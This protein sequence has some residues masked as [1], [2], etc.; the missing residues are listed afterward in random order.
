[1]NK[2][3]IFQALP[4]PLKNLAASYR[5]FQ[6]K[7]IRTKKREEFLIEIAKKDTWDKK[8]ISEFQSTR[9][10]EILAYS[11]LH[12]PYYRT[13]W[14]KIHT[15]K[16]FTDHLEISNW[17]ILEKETIRNNPDMFISDEVKK[18]ELINI[19]T[20]GTTGKPMNFWFDSY[21][22]SYWYAL[23]EHRIKRWNGVDDSDRWANVGGQ[24]IYNI[25][26]NKPPFWTWNMVMKQLYLSSYHITPENI[27]HYLSALKKYKIKYLLGYV[28]SIYNLANEGLKQ[29]LEFPGLSLVI[30]NAEPLFAHQR[31][32]IEKAF[33]CKVIQTYSGCEFAFSAN[34]D[35]NQDMYIWP[36][37]GYLE[38]VDQDGK[39]TEEGGEL[40]TTGLLN[41]AMPLIRYRVGDT[42]KINKGITGSKNFDYIE[43]ISGRTDDLVRTRDGKLVGR[44]DP[45]FKVDLKIKEA[46]I[47][48][49]DYDLFT[50]KIVADT[51]FSDDDRQSISTRLKERVGENAI[52]NFE[53]VDDIPRGAN[54]KFKA[55]VSK[56]KSIS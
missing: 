22:I 18:S 9:L 20:S 8:M 17:P 44:L 46:Q 30:T 29:G 40:V 41:K 25:K 42:V 37:A 50:V 43:E 32:I 11:I 55:V 27:I 26:K 23:Y 47:I 54:G 5:G 10:K 52:V 51:D 56:I 12:I 21:T 7:K 33:K 49:E 39:N 16:P 38:T 28:S 6:L 45:V 13:L 14:E 4:F 34:E 24:L 35:L 15:E 19:P 3:Q 36:E 53:L 2:L 48:Q 1:L 31:P